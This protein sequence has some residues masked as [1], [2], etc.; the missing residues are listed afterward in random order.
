MKIILMQRRRLSDNQ[1][2]NF[3]TLYSLN[4]VQNIFTL[5]NTSDAKR[6]LLPRDPRLPSYFCLKWYIF[7]S[8]IHTIRNNRDIRRIYWKSIFKII[9]FRARVR[10]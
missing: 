4:Q 5:I 8:K 6:K 2:I 1:K 10:N 3:S 7:Q 9:S